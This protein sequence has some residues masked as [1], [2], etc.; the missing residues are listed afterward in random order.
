[1]SAADSPFSDGGF[2]VL[3]DGDGIDI[4]ETGREVGGVFSKFELVLALRANDSSQRACQSARPIVGR[5]WLEA[6]VIVSS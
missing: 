2:S 3:V 1:M 4:E 6:R 5:S